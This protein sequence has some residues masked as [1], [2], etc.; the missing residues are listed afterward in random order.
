MDA[1]ETAQRWL[2]FVLFYPRLS[3]FI[4]GSFLWSGK[5]KTSVEGVEPLV[6]AVFALVFRPG[7]MPHWG[8]RRPKRKKSHKIMV[9]AQWGGSGGEFEIFCP[10]KRG[11]RKFCKLLAINA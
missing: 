7:R 9:L 8:A 2:A 3:V 4:R 1:D 11:F 10:K 6:W 5:K